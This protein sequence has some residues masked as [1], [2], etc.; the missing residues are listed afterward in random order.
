MRQVAGY[1]LIQTS[2]LCRDLS[3]KSIVAEELASLKYHGL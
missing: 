3:T 1:S 2:T